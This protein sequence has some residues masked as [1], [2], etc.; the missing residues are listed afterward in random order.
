MVLHDLLSINDWKIGKFLAIVLFLQAFLVGIIG[1]NMLDLGSLNPYILIVRDVIAFIYLSFIPG[2]LLLRVLRLHGLNPAQSI[3]YSVGLS[4]GFLMFEGLLLNTLGPSLGILNPF[5]TLPL[6][7]TVSTITLLLCAISFMRDRSFAECSIGSVKISASSA[8]VLCGL[9]IASVFGIFLVNEC[10]INILLMFLLATI[11]LVVIPATADRLFHRKLYPL[12]VIAIAVALLYSISLFSPY[13]VGWDVHSEYYF[14]KL[15][16]TNSIWDLTI[17]NNYNAMLSVSIL[18]AI[19]AQ[20]MNIDAAWIFKIVYPL[21]YSLVPLG[22]FETY[23]KQ[24]SP[25]IAFLSVFFFMSLYTFFYEMTSLGRQEIAELF[26]VILLL[27]MIDT[28]IPSYK[29]AVLSLFFGASLV[30]SHYGLS[31]LYILYLL[32]ASFFLFLLKKTSLGHLREYLSRNISLM[33]LLV[34]AFTYYTMVSSSSPFEDGVYAGIRMV[35]SLTDFFTLQSRGLMF[36]HAIGL[37]SGIVQHPSLLV[38]QY[39][40][41]FLI[42]VGVVKLIMKRKETTFNR[43]YFAM[44]LTSGVIILMGLLFPAFGNLLNFSRMYHFTLFFLAPFCV[45]GGVACVDVVSRF[46]RISTS[47]KQRDLYGMLLVSILLTAY[48]LLNTGFVYEVTGDTPSSVPLSMQRMETS[49]Q[50]QVELWFR[51]FYVSKQDVFCA[52]WLSATRDLTFK[53]YADLTSGSNVLRSYGAIPGDDI[54]TISNATR[55]TQNTYIYLS[56]MNIF[57]GIMRSEAPSHVEFWNTSDISSLL[58]HADK[59]YSNGFSE[60]YKP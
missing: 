47:H 23:R 59:V 17:H 21:I 50:V 26:I 13:L 11:P 35:N 31:Y 28:N 36:S 4:L 33:F 22:L 56:Q 38:V 5:S 54:V 52:T 7:S 48:F 29:K 53:V 20:F 58:A 3:L 46:F 19:Y 49:N 12:A 2:L 34:F 42:V 55:P 30:V 9:P 27:L 45:L 60:V 25:K 57:D 39:A 14:A 51:G 37:G 24:T 43:E 10:G 41:Q 8:L 6:V 32:I 44:T 15:V 18:P 16:Q 40:T 1:S